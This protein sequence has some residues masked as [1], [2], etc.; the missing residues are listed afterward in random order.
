MK[1]IG[2]GLVMITAGLA[3]LTLY[4]ALAGPKLVMASVLI[5]IGVVELVTLLSK[6]FKN[7]KKGSDS[8]IDIGKSL[9]LFH[10]H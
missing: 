2:K 10:L 9:I 8:L 7:I 1:D 5:L 6:N 3:S 4:I